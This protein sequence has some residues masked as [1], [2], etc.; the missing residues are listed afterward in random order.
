MIRVWRGR[1]SPRGV[2]HSHLLHGDEDELIVEYEVTDRLRVHPD[3]DPVSMTKQAHAAETDINRIVSRYTETGV[4]PRNPRAPMYGD[5]SD[6][7]SYHEM[8]NR[9]HQAQEDFLMLPVAVRRA[10]DNDPGKFLEMVFDPERVKELEE[11]GL[12]KRHLP[13][14]AEQEPAEPGSSD[15]VTEEK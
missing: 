5:F 12:L 11:L 3:S 1:R 14:A 10:C 15:L 2:D 8:A 6:F 7:G 13:E 4:W 9:V